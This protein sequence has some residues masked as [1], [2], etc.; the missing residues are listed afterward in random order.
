VGKRL[1]YFLAL[2]ATL[3][4]GRPGYRL[5]AGDRGPPLDGPAERAGQGVVER[6][7][8]DQQLDLRRRIEPQFGLIAPLG[9]GVEVDLRHAVELVAVAGP[10]E[11]LRRLSARPVVDFHGHQQRQAERAELLGRHGADHANGV[12]PRFELAQVELQHRAP[13]AQTDH[14]H[15]LG[16]L[17]GGP[18]LGVARDP[19]DR[20]GILLH[21]RL[22]R[23]RQVRR[24][25][26]SHEALAVEEAAHRQ[27]FEHV[28]PPVLDRAVVEVP[29]G[30]LTLG[31]PLAV[32]VAHVLGRLALGHERGDTAGVPWLL[33]VPGGKGLQLHPG[34]RP[35]G[36]VV[37]G[38]DGTRLAE[39]KEGQRR[40]SGWNGEAHGNVSAFV[41]T[42]GWPVAGSKGVANA[43]KIADGTAR[44][45]HLSAIP[46]R[47]I[48]RPCDTAARWSALPARP[49]AV[50]CRS[51]TVVRTAAAH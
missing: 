18:G 37:L 42:G 3:G 46:R 14:R 1:G 50:S 20:L 11:I 34:E 4:Q 39:Q 33:A 51:P 38:P 28:G 13:R 44:C 24:D 27:V 48:M 29:L 15:R 19:V 26:V 8:V 17:A 25:P 32:D 7:V 16:L 41:A 47:R 5:G 23:T 2:L 36:L 30:G 49:T 43:V 35:A 45:Q 21:V 40:P 22:G 10:R 12:K 6:D 9:W 31:S